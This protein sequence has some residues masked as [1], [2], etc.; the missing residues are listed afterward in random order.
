VSD[1]EEA[2]TGTQRICAGH[3]PNS[4]SVL[5]NRPVHVLFLTIWTPDLADK[6]NVRHR[7]L[8]LY[9]LTWLINQVCAATYRWRG[10]KRVKF[11]S[12]E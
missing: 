2:A 9:T 10:V 5:H 11:G 6:V 12:I 8:I 7:P 4:R 3:P 1:G